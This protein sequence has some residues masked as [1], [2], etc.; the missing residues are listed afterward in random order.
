MGTTTV[1]NEDGEEVEVPSEDLRYA[2]TADSNVDT[3]VPGS[4]RV[5]YTYV[6]EKERS[7]SVALAVVVE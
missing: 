7:T 1:V 4:Y 5:V 2:V 6:N 3:Q